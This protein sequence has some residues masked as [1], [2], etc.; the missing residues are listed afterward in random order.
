MAVS[1]GRGASVCAGVA[2]MGPAR[3]QDDI[4]SVPAKRNCQDPWG[5]DG[6]VAQHLLLD[7]ADR[8]VYMASRCAFRRVTVS[9][10]MWALQDSHSQ[11]C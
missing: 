9:A 6:T 8:G 7:R 3:T 5:L 2:W 10:G 1:P 4:L 11:Q